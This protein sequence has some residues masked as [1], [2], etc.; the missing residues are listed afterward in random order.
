MPTALSDDKTLCKTAFLVDVLVALLLGFP[1]AR[2]LAKD[3]RFP[4][5]MELKHLLPNLN[6]EQKL[7]CKS[8]ETLE[9]TL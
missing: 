6:N 8:M 2:Y 7:W 1:I 4:C 5:F 3:N 9:G